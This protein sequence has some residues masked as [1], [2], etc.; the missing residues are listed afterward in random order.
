MYALPLRLSSVCTSWNVNVHVQN[1]TKCLVPMAKHHSNTTERTSIHVHVQVEATQPPDI[2]DSGGNSHIV[3]L[4]LIGSK[5]CGSKYIPC[6][7]VLV[8]H[9]LLHLGISENLD[10]RPPLVCICQLT[11]REFDCRERSFTMRGSEQPENFQLITPIQKWTIQHC[12]LQVHVPT[13]YLNAY[14][15]K[16]AWSF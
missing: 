15:V 9:F 10:G 16:K 1:T 6:V 4:W 3:W 12:E 11:H 13:I 8:S 2:E 14:T 5:S 7:S